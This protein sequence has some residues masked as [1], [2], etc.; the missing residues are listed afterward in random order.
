MQTQIKRLIYFC[1]IG[2]LFAMAVSVF[3][4]SWLSGGLHPKSQTPTSQQIHTCWLEQIHLS[5]TQKAQL[6]R[7]RGDIQHKRKIFRQK[8]ILARKDIA[9]AITAKQPNRHS[10]HQK[11]ID[12]AKL[13]VEMQKL[14]VEHLIQVKSI[15]TPQQQ[16]DFKILL[17]NQI[18][19]DIYS[20]AETKQGK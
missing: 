9:D 8:A 14:V 20:T 6:K 1:V 3:M 11:L 13:Q 5:P 19:R 7:L 16:N 2:F 4:V 15:L 18:F 12:L 17:R 10:I